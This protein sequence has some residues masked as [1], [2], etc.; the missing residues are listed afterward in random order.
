MDYK[1]RS[2]VVRFVLWIGHA[3]GFLEDG[4]EVDQFGGHYSS[5]VMRP[6][7]LNYN[8]D[9]KDNPDKS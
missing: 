3:R 5:P 2:A 4:I 6:Q 9:N 7:D 1:C 8:S